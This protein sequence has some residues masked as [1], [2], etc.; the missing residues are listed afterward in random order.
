MTSRIIRNH[1]DMGGWITFLSRQSFPMTVSHTK[2]A[3]RTNP[4]NN[5]IH[6]WYGEVAKRLDDMDS[7]DVRAQCKLTF[8]VPILRRDNEAFRADYDEDFRPLPYETKLR[9]FRLLDPAITSLMTTKQLAEYQDAMMQHYSQAGIY[10]TDPSL[11]GWDDENRPDM[12]R[13]DKL[14]V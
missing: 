14:G 10:L 12:E 8:G 2:G 5:T 4:Q 9:L 11:K 3:K 1:E 13:H 7:L 6:M